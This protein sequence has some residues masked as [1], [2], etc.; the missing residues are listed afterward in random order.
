LS[1]HAAAAD[2]VALPLAQGRRRRAARPNSSPQQEVYSVSLFDVANGAVA[3]KREIL[4]VSDA[5]PLHCSV[6]QSPYG[7][8]IESVSEWINKAHAMTEKMRVQQ[9][10]AAKAPVLLLCIRG[11]N[12]S[13]ARE[14]ANP[15]DGARCASWP[16]SCRASTAWHVAAHDVAPFDVSSSSSSICRASIGHLARRSRDDEWTAAAANQ[17]Q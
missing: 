12:E 8:G 3:P 11:S 15:V 14:V 9:G 17:E 4:G 5:V 13:E 2:V 6:L 7:G 16:K 10:L 1:L